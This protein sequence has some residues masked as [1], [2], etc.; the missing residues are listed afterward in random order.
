[1]ISD[2]AA[3]SDPDATKLQPERGRCHLVQGAGWLEHAIPDT[4][5]RRP[6][7]WATGPPPGWQE[8][9]QESA[10]QSYAFSA[11]TSTEPS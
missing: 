4:L 5:A 10:S 8:V 2:H 6:L 11:R 3:A 9:R 7:H 1:M